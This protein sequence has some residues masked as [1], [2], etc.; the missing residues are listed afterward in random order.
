MSA[1]T[2]GVRAAA[3]ELDRA[4]TTDA[5]RRDAAA[6]KLATM[7]FDLSD[8]FSRGYQAGLANTLNR[9]C[10]HCKR[11]FEVPNRWRT[12]PRCL[13]VEYADG[14]GY[15]ILDDARTQ[16]VSD[17]FELHTLISPDGFEI[18]WLFDVDLGD[19]VQCP[20]HKVPAHEELGPLPVVFRARIAQSRVAPAQLPE[21]RARCGKPTRS[22]KPCRNAP[23]C[24]YH[25]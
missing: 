9:W 7:E 24:K 22:G 15:T 3:D 5:E 8:E 17:Q 16:P 20:G 23:S 14:E 6:Q 13:S 11:V 2:S 4:T 21:T 25:R 19:A 18:L 12:C 1:F 10:R